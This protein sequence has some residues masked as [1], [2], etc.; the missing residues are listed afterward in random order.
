M[1]TT[2]ALAALALQAQAP[3]A[4][5]PQ[6]DSLDDYVRAQIAMRKVPGLSLAIVDRGR[7]IYAKGYGVTAPGG[8]DPVTTDTRFLAG[9]ISK[10][11]AAMGALSLVEG[12]P[13]TLDGN[14]NRWLT[15]WQVPASAFTQAEPVTLRRI[16]SHTAG[17]TVHGFAG[18]EV[19]TPVPTTIQILDGVP[20]A[21]SAPIRVDTTPGAI[22]R[23]SGGGYTVMQ[24]MMEDVTGQ[25]FAAWMG[26]HVLAPLGMSKSSFRQPPPDD[27]LPLTAA[28]QYGPGRPV[29][30]RW[31]RYPE[32]AAAGLWTTASD[33]ARFIVGVQGSYTGTATPVLSEPMTRTMLTE[34]REGYGLGVGVDSSTGKLFFSH[35][36]RDD[37]FDAYM[38]GYATTGQGIVLMIN[39][40]DNSGMM[41]RIL[42]RV[43]L[44]YGWPGSEPPYS[45]APVAIPAARLASYGGRYEVANNQMLTLVPEG[46]S[47]VS[48]MDGLPDRVFLPTAT[49]EVTSDDRT[50]RFTFEHDAAGRILGFSRPIGGAP[51]TAPRIG[52]L[53]GGMTPAPDP[54]PA[55]TARADSALRALAAGGAAAKESPVLAPG[56]KADFGRPQFLLDGFSGLTFLLAE[57]VAGRGIER[58]GGAVATVLSYRL[59]G[60]VRGA[61]VL[62]YLTADGLVTDYDVV[63]N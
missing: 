46:T 19:G 33:L 30:G 17:L 6:L 44:M 51:V 36:G 52:P 58:H 2:L 27:F 61:F 28:G 62:V 49:W 3:A 56:A 24:L 50:R 15:T 48:L 8:A 26:G 59:D 38:G 42:E 40:N 11:V 22:W 47:V 39:A 9:S 29:P 41:R 54:D 34:V 14:V 45:L 31:H 5:T 18:Y 32:M 43:A 21:N 35:G 1:L 37:G 25:P 57:D 55:R 7:V 60:S 10:S 13:L 23:Y 53:L 4:P 20:P 16:L 63:D 12:G